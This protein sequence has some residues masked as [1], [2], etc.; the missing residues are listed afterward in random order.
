MWKKGPTGVLKGVIVFD[1]LRHFRSDRRYQSDE[2]DN[3]R[4]RVKQ[5]HYPRNRIVRWNLFTTQ[6]KR[7][8]HANYPC[9]E[10]R[11][12]KPTKIIN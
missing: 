10:E 3:D 1:Q 5:K 2:H 6:G 9:S 12:E 7:T 11:Q 8:N 4:K